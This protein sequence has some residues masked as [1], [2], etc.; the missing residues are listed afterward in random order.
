MRKWHSPL[1]LR[2]FYLQMCSLE[3]NF[4]SKMH[5]SIAVRLFMLFHISMKQSLSMPKLMAANIKKYCDI[6]Y[7][8]KSLELCNISVSGSRHKGD[9]SGSTRW[10]CLCII[11]HCHIHCVHMH[12]FQAAQRPAASALMWCSMHGVNAPTGCWL[13]S[14]KA[15]D[16]CCLC[17][18]AI[19]V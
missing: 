2:V 1:G 13:S 19:P 9:G 18:A 4:A 5:N 14:P 7:C 6:H 11:S 17:L 16:A 10:Q 15:S 3:S 12:D 8:Y